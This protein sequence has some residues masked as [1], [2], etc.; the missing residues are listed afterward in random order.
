MLKGART[1]CAIGALALTLAIAACGDDDDSSSESGGKAEPAATTQSGTPV[2]ADTSALQLKA[3][4]QGGL[5]FD[6]KE[7]TAKA[8]EVTIKMENPSS[9]QMPHDISIEGEGVEQ[10]GEVVQPGGTSEVKADLKPGTYTFYCSVGS[11]R[12]A[13]ME[14]TLTVQ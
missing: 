7:L 8:G 2:P 5:S 3:Q 11:H 1:V 10:K 9:D 6:K 13:G 14:G 4:E 12:Q